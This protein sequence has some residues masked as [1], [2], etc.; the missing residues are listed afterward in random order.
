MAESYYKNVS[1][2]WITL[3]PV[4]IGIQNHQ[5]YAFFQSE[6]KMYFSHPL[7]RYFPSKILLRWNDLAVM[8]LLTHHHPGIPLCFLM[9]NLTWFIAFMTAAGSNGRWIFPSFEFGM[10]LMLVL[11]FSYQHVFLS[12]GTSQLLT[13]LLFMG[14]HWWLAVLCNSTQ[15]S[16][17]V[18]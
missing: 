1:F 18:T 5:C 6:Y 7:Q 8:Q 12:D 9:G 10:I 11:F 17:K 13:L 15:V 4:F 3:S 14:T 2:R 16:A